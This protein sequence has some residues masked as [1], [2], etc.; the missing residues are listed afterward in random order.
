MDFLSNELNVEYGV[1]QGSNLGRLL[2][3]LFTNDIAGCII[4]TNRFKNESKNG[5]RRSISLIEDDSII[6]KSLPHD[7][8][9]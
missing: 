9:L 6:A 7:V 4:T 8:L 5:V 2:F 3:L 1:P